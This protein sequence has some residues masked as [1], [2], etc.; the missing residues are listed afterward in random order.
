MPALLRRMAG[1]TEEE[2]GRG[3][4]LSASSVRRRMGVHRRMLDGDEE[5]RA[6]AIGIAEEILWG[7]EKVA[8][9]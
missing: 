4:G 3:F 7:R 6:L 8:I 2:V 9:C 1:Q 5:Y